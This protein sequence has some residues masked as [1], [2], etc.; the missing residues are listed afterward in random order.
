MPRVGGAY[1]SGPSATSAFPS[2][3]VLAPVE[4][5]EMLLSRPLR[6]S[7]F[8]EAAPTAGTNIWTRSRLRR[9]GRKLTANLNCQLNPRQKP[10]AFP[11]QRVRVSSIQQRSLTSAVNVTPEP[12]AQLS[13]SSWLLGSQPRS[14]GRRLA[15]GSALTPETEV[16]EPRKRRLFFTSASVETNLL[17]NGLNVAGL[18]K[19]ETIA[20]C[21]ED[22]SE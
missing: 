8:M 17:L 11:A 18:F 12:E 6:G 15:A 7:L 22:H 13:D 10:F 9:D 5:S 3:P 20:G 14:C 16:R 19:D 21:T 2:G 4:L 1:W